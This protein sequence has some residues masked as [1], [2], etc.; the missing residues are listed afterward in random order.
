MDGGHFET[1]GGYSLCGQVM[2]ME[3]MVIIQFGSKAKRH[4]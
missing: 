3:R 1:H 4:V 2:V